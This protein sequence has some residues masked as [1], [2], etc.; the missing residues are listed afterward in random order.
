[1]YRQVAIKFVTP[2]NDINNVSHKSPSTDILV[3]L[4][5][6]GDNSDDNTK[7]S[8]TDHGYISQLKVDSFSSNSHVSVDDSMKNLRTNFDVYIQ[9][10]ISQALDSNFLEEIYRENG[11]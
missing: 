8:P 2:Q 3:K 9:T 4:I 5:S 11:E 6:D 7:V 10:L 1:M